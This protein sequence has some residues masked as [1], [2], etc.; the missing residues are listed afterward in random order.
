MKFNVNGFMRGDSTER[1]D[2]YLK[3]AQINQIAYSTGQKPVLET[4]EMRDWEDLDPLPESDTPVA[5]PA[6]AAD[7]EDDSMR[8]SADMIELRAMV[9]GLAAG[10]QGQP[11]TVNLPDVR[12]DAPQIHVDSELIGRAIGDMPAPI[13][14]VN[15]NPTPVDVSVTNDV[16]PAAVSVTNEVHTP[17]AM[18]N[19]EVP[20]TRHTVK[21]DGPATS[22]K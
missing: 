13:V 18:V 15:V 19:V 8:S 20:R 12:V 16:Q 5:D 22:S 14:N 6:A 10:N 7:P 1:W 3:A 17:P 4:D 21:R 11:V 9:A 2:T